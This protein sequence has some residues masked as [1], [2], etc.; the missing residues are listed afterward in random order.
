MVASGIGITVLPKTSVPEVVPRDSLLR[1]VPFEKPAPDRR[2]VL[3]WRK[4]FPRLAAIETIR[5]A[6][7]DCELNGV[8]KLA[9][10]AGPV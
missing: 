1:Y 6:V 10:P 3:V 4:T 7:L 2:V 8:K 5:Q 9:L